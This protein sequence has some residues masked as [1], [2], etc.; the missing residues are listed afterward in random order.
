[1]RW[2]ESVALLVEQLAKHGMTSFGRHD[3]IKL[4]TSHR[5]L[6]CRIIITTRTHHKGTPHEHLDGTDLARP[7]RKY[8]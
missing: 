7:T 4:A 1:M 2:D 8:W 6:D 5:I 3:A